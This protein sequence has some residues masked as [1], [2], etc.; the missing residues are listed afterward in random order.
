LVIASSILIGSFKTFFKTT[1]TNISSDKLSKYHNSIINQTTFPKEKEETP[2]WSETTSLQA[3]R[4]TVKE[5]TAPGMRRHRGSKGT[6]EA[7]HLPGTGEAKHLSEEHTRET[8]QDTESGEE[9][10]SQEKLRHL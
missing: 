6:G 3:K 1:F 9:A 4:H 10:G 7:K 2:S 8:S 5:G